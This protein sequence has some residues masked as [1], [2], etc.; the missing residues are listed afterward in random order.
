MKKTSFIIFYLFFSITSVSAD[1]TKIP[2][3]P[4]DNGKVIDSGFTKTLKIEW[5]GGLP[6]VDVIIEG[7][8]Y[9]FLFDTGAVTTIPLSLRDKLKLKP[10]DNDVTV[11]DSAGGTTTTQMYALPMMTIGGI[12]FSSFTVLANDFQSQFPLSC[13]GFEGIIGINT[14]KDLNIKLDLAGSSI[15]ISDI[16]LDT[17][18][19][20]STDFNYG[21]LGG[22]N[23]DINFEFGHASFKLDTGKNDPMQIGDVT[24][25]PELEKYKY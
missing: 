3:N 24:V 17:T 19:Y 1:S 4:F 8:K 14:L 25:V 12:R 11:Y 7:E 22:I 2:H 20:I 16:P 13:L 6:L 10:L 21:H 23:F 9:K 18:G 5:S 15:T